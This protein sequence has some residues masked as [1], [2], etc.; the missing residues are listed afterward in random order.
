MK[1][2]ILQKTRKPAMNKT[3]FYIMILFAFLITILCPEFRSFA[4]P[5]DTTYFQLNELQAGDP[6]GDLEI[7]IRISNSAPSAGLELIISAA[8]D[9]IKQM[10]VSYGDSL[11]DMDYSARL[12]RG[13]DR[14]FIILTARHFT[15]TSD[16]VIDKA[17]WPAGQNRK[18]ITLNLGAKN[19]YPKPI[20]INLY[21]MA[22]DSAGNRTS[23]ITLLHFD[24]LVP[25]ESE[26]ERPAVPSDFVLYQNYPNPFNSSTTI[27]YSVPRL[28]DVTLEIYN[29]AGQC[30]ATRQ[31]RATAGLNSWTWDAS[32]LASGFYF[33]KLKTE[34]FVVVK[35][36]SFIK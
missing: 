22:V 8:K 24:R 31:N 16:T 26:I 13:E 25:V 15:A 14:D 10:D 6:S 11:P 28:C 33:C 20:P 36:M 18:L 12:M 3:D 23:V 4:M 9:V 32:G 1:V 7:E 34:T 21:P 17:S 29:T 35:R 19:L 2:S 5:S 30:V 27:S